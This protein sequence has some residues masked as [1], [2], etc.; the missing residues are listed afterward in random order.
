MFDSSGAPERPPGPDGYPVIGSFLAFAR[1]AFAFKTR[2]SREYGPLTYYSSLGREF[3][4]LNDPELVETVL[5]HRNEQF[6]KG[7]LFHD[8]LDPV[9]GDGLLTAEGDQWRRQ[10]HMVNPAFHPD[11]IAEYSEIMVEETTAMADS[12]A[13]GE[14]VNV[15]SELMSVTLDIVSRTLFGMEVED[16]G[17]ISEALDVVM[18]RVGSPASS[19]VPISAP[20]PGNRAFFEAIDDIDDVVDDII[21]RHRAES[22]DEDSVLSTLLTARDD[23]GETMDDELVRDEVRT[24]LLAGHETTALALT[25]SLFCLGQNPAA[26]DL[27]VAELEDVLGGD[28]PTMADAPNLEYTEQVVEESMRLYPPVHGILREAKTD[29]AL[30]G[31]TIPEGATVN[32]N[33]W[34]L[35]RDPRFFDDPMAFDPGR[36]SDDLRE[37]LPRFA[38]FPFGGGPRRCVGDRFAKLEAKLVLAT[39]YQNRHFELVSEPKLSLLPSITTR[40]TEPVLMRVHER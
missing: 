16:G 13:D 19:L 14:T 34:T 25:F 31:Y 39:L 38:Y 33:Q 7:E 9:T 17:T 35:H 2:L 40:P 20:T 29:V 24:L 32:L 8:I 27:L 37:S 23:A 26:E 5:V 6:G 12:W 4:Q 18:D 28:R 1:D 15:H 36:W 30:G 3:Y 10:R 21:E 11:R 22:I